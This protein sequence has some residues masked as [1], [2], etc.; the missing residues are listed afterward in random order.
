MNYFWFFQPAL[1]SINTNL[2]V[3]L[4]FVIQQRFCGVRAAEM[5]LRPVKPNTEDLKRAMRLSN[6]FPS[7]TRCSAGGWHERVVLASLCAMFFVAVAPVALA[8]PERVALVLGNH[9]YAALDALPGCLTSSSTMSR[10]LEAL[11]YEVVERYNSSAGGMAGA[12]DA[13]LRKL[14]AAPGAS[15]LVYYCG[16][17]AAANDRLF[18]LPTPVSVLRPNDLLTQG[19]LAKSL[20]DVL[21]RGKTSRAMLALDLVDGDVFSAAEA[22][23]RLPSGDGTGLI[24]V[25]GDQGI[26]TPSPL[27]KTLAAGL[28]APDIDGAALLNQAEVVL[29]DTP[30]EV[31][32]ARPPRVALALLADELRAPVPEPEQP[33][34]IPAQEPVVD[35]PAPGAVPEQVAA[36]SPR[37]PEEDEMTPYQKRLV[38]IGLARIGLYGGRIDGLFGSETRAAIRRFQADIGAEQTGIITGEQAAKLAASP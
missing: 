24:V 12:V 33:E 19:V 3:R 21:E 13:F 5:I 36:S 11:D 14:K 38:Q 35:M 23:E 26:D 1:F 18:V 34:S 30:S 20:L 31:V 28:A 16:Y 15:A 2:I 37:F 32:A 6:R 29:A 17:A 25:S 9:K 4:E 27:A 7:T 22:L 8:A 10:A